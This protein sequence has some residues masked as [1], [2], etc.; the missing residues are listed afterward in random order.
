M[1]AKKKPVEEL[2]V[3]DLGLTDDD[4]KV[5]QN[6]VDISQAEARKAGEVLE[7]DGTGAAKIADY[8]KEAKVI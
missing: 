5:A 4:V 6:I 7:D 8:L 2:S 1:A 3:G